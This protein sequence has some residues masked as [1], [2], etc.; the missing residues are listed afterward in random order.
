LGTSY[1]QKLKTEFI[2]Y[3]YKRPPALPITGITHYQVSLQPAFEGRN[4]EL[5]KEYNQQRTEAEIKYR[6]DLNAWAVQVKA[7]NERYDRDLAEYNKKSLGTKVA[8]KAMLDNRKPVRQFIPK[9]YMETVQKPELQSTYDY[10]VVG[11]TYIRLDGYENMPANALKIQVLL[12]GYDHTQPRTMDEERS[13][14]SIGGGRASTTKSVLY[15]TEFSYRYPMAVKV[16][17]PDGKELLNVTPPELN[18]YKI[19][20]SPATDMPTKINA[21]LLLKT[22]Q[23]KVLQDNLQFINH[24]LN[25]KYGYTSVDRNISLYYIK[26]GDDGYTD[27]TTAFNEASS[28]LLML[29]QDATLAKVK[30]Q[31]A[32]AL[33]GTA[34]KEAD[35]NNKKARI[36]KDIAT[37]IYFNMLEAYFAQGNVPDGQNILEK[38]NS[39]SMSNSDRR[40]KLE[41]EMLFAELKS[42][43]SNS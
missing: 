27:L 20:Q 11:N 42:R 34:I 23:E 9:P 29:E 30:L 8:E 3:S 25:D 1:A 16:Y 12:Y 39:M 38:M 21:E 32:C 17:T 26:G 36:N 7:A 15:H 37:G 18:S 19:Y 5:L 28:G 40:L 14:L 33:W 35:M 10:S 6:N 13:N 4:V 2:K 22:A 31:K 43:Q 41:Y 24:L